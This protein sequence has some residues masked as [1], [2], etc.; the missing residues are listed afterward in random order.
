MQNV[1]NTEKYKEGDHPLYCH[2][3]EIPSVKFGTISI[4]LFKCIK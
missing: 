2:L 4:L 3:S 1:E